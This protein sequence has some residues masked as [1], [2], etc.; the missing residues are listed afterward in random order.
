MEML[1]LDSENA[2]LNQGVLFTQ[3][4]REGEQGVYRS[5]LPEI[6]KT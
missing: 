1:D 5:P 6:E 3:A 4:R 2:F